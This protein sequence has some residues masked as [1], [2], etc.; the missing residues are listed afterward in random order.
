M[1]TSIKAAIAFTLFLAVVPGTSYAG[2][3]S[4]NATSVRGDDDSPVVRVI[5]NI[6]HFIVHIL[7][8]PSVP[9]PAPPPQ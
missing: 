2:T 8:E 6:K 3:R 9:I 1:R 5:K 7:G 4:P